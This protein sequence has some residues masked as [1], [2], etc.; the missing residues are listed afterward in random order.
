MLT[1]TTYVNAAGWI[2]VPG[3][4]PYKIEKTINEDGSVQIV[5]KV[6]DGATERKLIDVTFPA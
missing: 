4:L 2:V 1:G 6:L 3:Q 5:W